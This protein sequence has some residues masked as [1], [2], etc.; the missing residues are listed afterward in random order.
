V[1]HQHFL[2]P[3]DAAVRLLRELDAQK[4]EGPVRA[5]ATSRVA[6]R[7]IDLVVGSAMLVALTAGVY[8]TATVAFGA[9]PVDHDLRPT[10]TG[11]ILSWA[12]LASGFVLLAAYEVLLTWRYGQTP[13]KR[14]MQIRVVNGDRGSITLRASAIR[15]ATW[16]V[17][18]LACFLAWQ[19]TFPRHPE[20]S[21]L[22]FFGMFVAFG[23]V[24]RGIWAAG[25]RGVHDRM[26][27]TAV[28]MEP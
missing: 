14:R 17:P 18:W 8:T 28:I 6:A 16:A 25:G 23:I 24:A 13:G 9:E 1:T 15:F 21:L 2:D 12:T 20:L 3:T 11:T 27:H 10:R 22:C 7:L 5:D 19:A 4:V 26:A